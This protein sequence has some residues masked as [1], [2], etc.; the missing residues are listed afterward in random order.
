MPE[1]VE[2]KF[3]LRDLGSTRERL[4]GCGFQEVTPRTHEMNTVYDTA[5]S[6]L[7]NR[8]ELLRLRQYGSKWTLTHKGIAKLGG[9]HK[10]RVETE[11]RVCDGAA[12]HSIL[13]AL[14]FTPRFKY[15]KFRT[16]YADAGHQG[17][18]VIDETPIGNVGEIE[19]PP[20]WIDEVA[21]QLGVERSE[22]ITLSYSA[23]FYAWRERN[24]SNARDMTWEAL[25]LEPKN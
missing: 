19:G 10:S 22:Y 25:G 12:M 6:D 3:L 13:S 1:E 9:P 14:G 4:I 20:R 8:G 18:V 23:L 17:H 2:I 7:R 21:R 16:E 15:E 24:G 11:T 5:D